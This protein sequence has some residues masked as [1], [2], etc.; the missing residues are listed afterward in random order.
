MTT[1]INKR[2]PSLDG[3]R[4][5]SIIMVVLGHAF[6]KHFKYIDIANLGVNVFFVISAYLIVG[7]LLRDVQMDRFSIRTFYFKRFTR[8]FP[9]FYSYILILAI[10]LSFSNL[11]DWEQFWRAPVFLENYHARSLW[12]GKQWFV[13][14][15]WSLA[16][17]EQFYI[18]IA[19]I[20]LLINKKMVNLN[21]LLYIFIALIFLIPVIRISYLYFTSIPDYL[22]GSI[23]RS[24]E[25]VA[26]S[27]ALG[28]ILAVSA[29]R[30]LASKWILFFKNRIGVLL[31]IILLMQ[32]FNSS[33]IVSNYGLAPRYFYNLFGLTI[34]NICLGTLLIVSINFS[35]ESYFSRFLNRPFMILI[36][37]WSYSIYLW[38]QVW[39]YSW[40][41]PIIYKL[42]GLLLC[43]VSSYYFIER[44]FLAWRDAY[45]IKKENNKSSYSAKAVELY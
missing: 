9:A 40:D 4:A 18:I 42:L 32:G 41:L 36:G 37:L 23:H 25:T 13:G 35:N 31:L 14:H 19:F 12:N 38:Q 30:I 20:F 24:F 11:F 26:D 22:R 27:L 44:K 21:G 17:E 2:I 7:I 45:I 29:S 6:G 10:F 28:G 39:L 43:A 1:A 34:I 16:V 33:W 15:T 8:T 3:L 5:I